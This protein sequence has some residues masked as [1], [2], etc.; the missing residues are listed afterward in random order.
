MQNQLVHQMLQG[1]IPDLAYIDPETGKEKM[2]GVKFINQCL[3]E[4]PA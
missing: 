2:V 3:L 4:V 1:A